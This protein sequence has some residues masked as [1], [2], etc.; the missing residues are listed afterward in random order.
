MVLLPELFF[1][2][3]VESFFPLLVYEQW[4]TL[5]K[6]I[7]SMYPAMNTARTAWAYADEHKTHAG[8]SKLIFNTTDKTAQIHFVPLHFTWNV[9]K[10][11]KVLGVLFT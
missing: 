4:T 1:I 11:Q 2:S 10:M 3:F 9:L 8:P 5:S 7:L 6:I